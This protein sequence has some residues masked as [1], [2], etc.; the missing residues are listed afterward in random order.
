MSFYRVCF[1]FYGFK[2]WERREAG[3]EG[4]RG[5]WDHRGVWGQALVTPSGQ[6][7]ALLVL[8]WVW[9][10][11]ARIPGAYKPLEELH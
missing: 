8:N 1:I 5:L 11:A 7:P 2:L 10:S 9:G 6:G 3:R 4:G